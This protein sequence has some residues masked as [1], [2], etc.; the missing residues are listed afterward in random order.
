MVHPTTVEPLDHVIIVYHQIIVTSETDLLSS[1]FFKSKMTGT[2]K[3]PM[4]STDFIGSRERTM[5]TYRILTGCTGNIQLIH[6]GYYFYKYS[7][8]F[9]TSLPFKDK[10]PT[11]QPGRSGNHGK[12]PP[13]GS[14]VVKTEI[15]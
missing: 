9:Q 6:M 11:K 14:N 5:A 12:T 8:R 1:H 2:N 4:F 10:S 15:L 13:G 3:P 7:T